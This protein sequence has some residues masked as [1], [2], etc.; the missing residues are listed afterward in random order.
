MSEGVICQYST[1]LYILSQLSKQVRL[2]KSGSHKARLVTYKTQNKNTTDTNTH[3]NTN[4]IIEY[5]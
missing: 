3:A 5:K 1:E 4:T 2:W